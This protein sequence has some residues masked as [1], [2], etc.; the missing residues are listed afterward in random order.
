MYHAKVLEVFIAS[1]SDVTIERNLTEKIVQEWNAIHSKNNGTILLPMRWEKNVYSDFSSTPQNIINKQ[2]L[3]NA[4]VLI[5]IFWSKIGTPTKEHESGT[6]EELRLHI[7]AK[8]PAIVVFSKKPLPQDYDRVQFDQLQLFKKWCQSCGV[9]FEF[10]R[11]NDFNEL[12][13]N[14]LS[15]VLNK[16][17]LSPQKNI[18]HNDSKSIA[19]TNRVKDDAI[20]FIK[21][22][23]LFQQSSGNLQNHIDQI[24]DYRTSKLSGFLKETG[25]LTIR[26]TLGGRPVLT[27]QPRLSKL[28]KDDIEL[29]T[30]DVLEGQYDHLL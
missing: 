11:S 12:I 6:V 9:Y 30:N 24:G 23:P 15:L 7:E 19:K 25:L 3:E 13:R 21:N 20:E 10:E 2:I 1:P 29:F 17:F 18:F 27:I 22:I 5:A 16:N 4:D 28:S 8:K 26:H 14:Q